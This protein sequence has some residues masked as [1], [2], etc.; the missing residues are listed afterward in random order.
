MSVTLC[1]P[2]P[3]PD[4]T[5]YSLFCRYHV[6]S[7]NA[8]NRATIRQL[9]NKNHSMQTT[10]FSA[11]PLKYTSHW[12]ETFHGMSIESLIQKNTAMPFY[13]VFRPRT[14]T[15]CFSYASDRFFMGMYNSCCTPNKKLRYCPKCAQAQWNSFGVSYWQILPQI[16]GYEICHIHKEP[17]CETS[18]S[19]TNVRYRFFPASTIISSDDDPLPEE[20]QRLNDIKKHRKQFLQLS[21]DIDFLFRFSYP[22]FLLSEKIRH[23]L[24][25][26]LLPVRRKWQH[27]IYNSPLHSV[28]MDL[29][30][31][32][33]SIGI[34]EDIYSF[35]SIFQ[36]LPI[37]MQIS[38]CNEM[39]GSIRNVCNL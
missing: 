21:E 23:I 37:Y 25:H 26:N 6:R 22:G 20:T 30:N 32:K 24:A 9:F 17:I 35:I 2:T 14:N 4:E 5:I 29:H 18:I 11:F 27:R 10:V 7:C 12:V 31:E 19:H 13:R 36:Y 34:P 8:S 33:N 38:I 3:L 28:C 1:F 15:V 39:F 16:N